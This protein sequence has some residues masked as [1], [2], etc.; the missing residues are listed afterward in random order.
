M[1]LDDPL[2]WFFGTVVAAGLMVYRVRSNR[3]EGRR[4]EIHEKV[5]KAI[6]ISQEIAAQAIEYYQMDGSNLR[7]DEVGTDIRKKTRLLGTVITD[8][9]HIFQDQSLLSAM[10]RFRKSSTGE[11]DTKLRK[12]WLPGSSEISSIEETCNSLCNCL[13]GLFHSR[14]K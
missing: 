14:F 2:L 8:L 1:R 11:L 3:S 7:C 5:Q 13:L 10:T 6:D 12:A 9:H 4:R